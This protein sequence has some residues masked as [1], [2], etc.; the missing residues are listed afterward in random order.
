MGIKV[1]QQLNINDLVPIIDWTFFFKAWEM[2]GR[3]PALLEDPV[4][5]NEAK[6]LFADANQLLNQIIDQNLLTVSAVYGL[7]PAA[8]ENDSV[9]VY[10]NNEKSKELCRFHFLRN[11]QKREQHNP[12]LADFIAPKQE[13][14][15]DYIGGFAVTAGKGLAAITQKYIAEGNEYMS[16]M[17]KILADRLAEAAAEWLHFYVRTTAWGYVPNELFDPQALLK[18]QYRGIR[19]AAGYPASPDHSEKDTLFNLLAVTKNIGIELT[20]T[21]AMLPT[22]SVSGWYF[23]NPDAHYFLVEQIGSE[24]LADLA[25]RKGMDIDKLRQFV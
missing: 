7:F 11:L 9:I 18:G 1:I 6:K 12:C 15:K 5:A 24:Q 14:C 17:A 3:Y 19:P 23:A 22:A 13:N 20:E 4:Q 16:I 8:S 25:K 2:K 21:F 10:D